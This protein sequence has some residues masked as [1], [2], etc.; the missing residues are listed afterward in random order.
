MEPNVAATQDRGHSLGPFYCDAVQAAETLIRYIGEDIDRDGLTGTP[1]RFVRAIQELTK[2]YS[3]IPQ[4]ILGTVFN[5]PYDE[6][7]VIGPI[8]FCSL[9]EHHILPFRGNAWVSYIPQEH[10]I[11]LSKIPRLVQC[12]AKRLQIQERLTQQIA[13]TLMEVVNPIGVACVVNA[14]HLCMSMRGIKSN[15][16]MTTS[17]MLG[18]FR[19][20]DND[21][22]QEFL[23]LVNPSC[24]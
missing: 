1:D 15:A 6:M 4:E 20:K 14:H 9:C 21:A 11:G 3:E 16:W 5:E 10:V 22:R 13:H 12:F 2:G 18:A 19:E 8:E 24:K 7:V 23:S 17:C